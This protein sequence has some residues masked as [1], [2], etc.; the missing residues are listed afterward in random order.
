[1]G[2]DDRAVV[3]GEEEEVDPGCYLLVFSKL[4][5]AGVVEQYFR[6]SWSRRRI[7]VAAQAAALP[8]DSTRSYCSGDSKGA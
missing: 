2:P 4:S 7:V 1:M 8:G 5:L 3:L 6:Q